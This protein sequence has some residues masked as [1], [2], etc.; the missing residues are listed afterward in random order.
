MADHDKLIDLKIIFFWPSHLSSGRMTTTN[1]LVAHRR[2]SMSSEVASE[3]KKFPIDH[4]SL[5]G[6]HVAL[7]SPTQTV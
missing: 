6:G 2:T 4:R 7:P 1:K 5:I 3:K